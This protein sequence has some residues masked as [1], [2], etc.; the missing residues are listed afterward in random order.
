MDLGRTGSEYDQTTLYKN[1]TEL[2]KYIL[3]HLHVYIYNPLH[4]LD[5]FTEH[6]M[7]YCSDITTYLMKYT[8]I[9]I[10]AYMYKDLQYFI[11]ICMYISF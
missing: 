2:I 8:F 3:N 10:C 6:Y 1:L 11:N 4:M 9:F 7:T 5:K